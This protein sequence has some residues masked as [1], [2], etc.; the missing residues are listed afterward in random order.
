MRYKIIKSPL[1]KKFYIWDDKEKKISS[2]N[3]FDIIL[4]IVQ[5]KIAIVGRK[6]F[7]SSGY[8]YYSTYKYRLMDIKGRPISEKVF[9]FVYPYDSF[10]FCKYNRLPVNKLSY[11]DNYIWDNASGRYIS[12]YPFYLYDS[13]NA[14]VEGEYWRECYKDGN[15]YQY[16]DTKGNVLKEVKVESNKSVEQVLFKSCKKDPDLVDVDVLACSIDKKMGAH[17][18]IGKKDRRKILQYLRF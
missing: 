13:N 16:I 17:K 15:V 8:Y 10:I 3:G 14:I 12:K 1:N 11:L 18:C 5:D 9:D 4:E 6:S 2:E 7:Y